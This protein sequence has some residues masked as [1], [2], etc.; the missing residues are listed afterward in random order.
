[1]I[2]S[3]ESPIL[4]LDEPFNGIDLETNQ[5]LKLILKKL[6]EQGK[7]IIIT[8]HILD[9]LFNVCDTISYLDKGMIKNEV[10]S[11]WLMNK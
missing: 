5:K 6:S 8:S 3:K 4:L 1:M 10:T 7:T 9:V 11:T 2:S